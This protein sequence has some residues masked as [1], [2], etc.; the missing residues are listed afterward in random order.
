V[1][2]VLV[3]GVDGDVTALMPSRFILALA[4][5]RDSWCRQDCLPRRHLL[6]RHAVA[7]GVG[8]YCR[9]LLRRL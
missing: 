9:P 6:H 8:L 2:I 3:A 5:I 4:P 1:S 7:H